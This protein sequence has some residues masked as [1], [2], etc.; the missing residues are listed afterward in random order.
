MLSRPMAL[1]AVRRL[2]RR[3]LDAHLERVGS[4]VILAVHDPVTI[5]GSAIAGF[6][7]Y[8]SAFATML[9]DLTG[10]PAVVTRIDGNAPGQRWKASWGR[11]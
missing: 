5:D 4:T 1:S 3:Y 2:A 8:A 10:V 9:E 11:A 6:A 7:F